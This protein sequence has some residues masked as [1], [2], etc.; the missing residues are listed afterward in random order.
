VF[1]L[2]VCKGLKKKVEVVSLSLTNLSARDKFLKFI[3]YR[4]I[5]PAHH[6]DDPDSS[7][8]SVHH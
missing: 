6:F 2:R 3:A 1:I 8:E 5:V 7:V 4:K